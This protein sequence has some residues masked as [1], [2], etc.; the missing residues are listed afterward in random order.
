M[1]YEDALLSSLE[2]IVSAAGPRLTR[3]RAVAAA[4]RGAGPYRWVGLYRVDHEEGMVCNVVWSGPAA[5]AFPNF[6]I[7]SGL[8]G[9]A[10]AQKRTV[11]VGSVL[12]DPRYLTALGSTESEIIVPVFDREGEKVIGTIDIESDQPN[13]FDRTTQRALER[14]AELIRPA[15]D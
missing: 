1:F 13:A 11:N 3:F 2:E 9:S 12:R 6:E 5:P 8:T 15:W 7:G 4:I 10:I 14:C